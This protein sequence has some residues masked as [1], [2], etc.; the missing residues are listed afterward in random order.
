EEAGDTALDEDKA[1]MRDAFVRFGEDVVRPHAEHIH[2]QDLTIPESL[3]DPMREMGVF[4]LSVPARFGGSAP[5]DRE[6]NLSMM[7][8]TEALSEASLA[9]AGSLITR[10]EIMTRALL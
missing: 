9:A 3:L 1:L 2:R 4:G 5:D 6:D 7:V 8:V 10:P